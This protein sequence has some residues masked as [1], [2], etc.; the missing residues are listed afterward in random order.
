M[1]IHSQTGLLVEVSQP[2]ILGGSWLE[3][4]D[5]SLLSW[6][7]TTQADGGYW[8]ATMKIT[9]RQEKLE[10]WIENGLGRQIT[11]YSPELTICWQGFVNS[12]ILNLGGLSF[13][14]GPFL[15]VRNYVKLVYS[16]VD[17]STTPP[18]MGVRAS[19]N[20]Y[21]STSSISKYG[22]IEK[23]LS[24]GGTTLANALQLAQM[25]LGENSSPSSTKTVTPMQGNDLSLM[26]EMLGNAHWLS[27]YYYNNTTTG[28]T[29]ALARIQA[30]MAASPTFIYSTDYTFM[31]ANATSIPAYEN[32][33]K[34]ALD[35][36]N[37][38]VALGDPSDYARYTF[39]IY[40]DK[41]AYYRKLPDSLKYYYR[42]SSNAQ[43]LETV[44]GAII[45][46]WLI[47]PAEW[48]FIPD[49]LIGR[50]RD[51]LEIQDDPRNIFIESVTYT[52]PYGL[53]VSG[54]S[55]NRLSQALAQLGLGGIGA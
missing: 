8:H 46:P 19:T 23:V 47:R 35:V 26:V 20:W 6:S 48:L 13:Q 27:T 28:T 21:S 30:I 50:V 31:D 5:R 39:G 45:R 7:H 4:I 41:K 2:A 9:D 22:R 11:L 17:T 12:I 10:E 14:H 34:T 43:L 33:D 49:F 44:D 18:T 3:N 53:T 52:A 25:Y 55:V 36:I 32:D 54:G 29:T 37:G 16:T 1:T 38:I 40:E 42:I 24:C 51:P 15:D